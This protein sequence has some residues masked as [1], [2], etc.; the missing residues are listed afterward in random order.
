[1]RALFTKNSEHLEDIKKTLDE[2]NIEYLEFDDEAGNNKEVRIDLGDLSQKELDFLKEEYGYNLTYD[3]EDY[4][5][6]IFWD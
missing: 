6:L 5:Y 1:M 4:T 3:I 2:E